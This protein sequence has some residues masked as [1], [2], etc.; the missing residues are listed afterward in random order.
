MKTFRSTFSSRLSASLINGVGVAFLLS[1][2]GVACSNDDDDGGGSG[3]DDGSAGGSTSSDSGDDVTGTGGTGGTTTSSTGG[4]FSGEDVSNSSCGLSSGSS[5]GGMGG[6]AS[7]IIDFEACAAESREAEVKAADIFVLLDQSISMGDHQVV[8]SDPDSPTR[9]EAL[10]EALKGFVNSPEAEGLRVGIQYFGLPADDGTVSCDPNVY[11]TPDVEIGEL[12]GNATPL[13]ESIDAHEPSNFTPSVPALEGALMHA[14]Q[15]A[16]DNPSRPTVVVFATDGYPTECERRS[17]SDLADVAEQYANPPEGTPRVPTFVLGVGE[18]PNLERV[19]KVSGE[20]HAFFVADCETAVEDLL[21]SLLRVANSPALCEFEMPTPDEGEIVDP[22]KVNM[23]FTP[24]GGDAEIVYRIA[25][26][27]ECGDGGWYY[28]DNNDPTQIRVCPE[29]CSTFG[30]GV[31]DIAVGC[32]T[33][34]P[35]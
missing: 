10:T 12:P 32:E 13:V 11:A 1:G 20:N 23:V 6:S 16:E 14:Q 4:S 3:T 19:A 31:V 5:M 27:A 9:W 29:T 18:V 8:E 15:W 25:S 7:D 17:I 22:D 24:D 34:S 2:V 21:A 28:D 33:L 26:S 30:G 35:E